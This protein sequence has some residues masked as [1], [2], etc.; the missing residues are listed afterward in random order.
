MEEIIK[1]EKQYIQELREEIA[2]LK[3]QIKVYKE[4]TTQN[5]NLSVKSNE[6]WDVEGVTDYI[7]LSE[8]DVDDMKKGF[9]V[10]E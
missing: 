7:K 9:E 5:T 1:T 6:A 8:E 4:I 2:N 3:G 10:D